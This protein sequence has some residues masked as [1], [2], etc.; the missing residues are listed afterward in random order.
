MPNS[1]SPSEFTCQKLD[2][3]G[4][5][6]RLQNAMNEYYEKLSNASKSLEKDS[7]LSAKYL[8]TMT[9]ND[10]LGSEDG[11]PFAQTFIVGNYCAALLG[12]QWVRC[13]IIDIA[14]NSAQIECVDDGRSLRM[15]LNKLENLIDQFKMLPRVAF[16]CKLALD[17][18]KLL[19]FNLDAIN[20]F[21]EMITQ[22]NKEFMVE[23]LNEYEEDFHKIFEVNLYH[24]DINVIDLLK[25]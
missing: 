11:D 25:S 22:I 23:I 3:L 21:K 7:K 4:R 14:S 24:N 2:L 1:F 17:S 20:K 10:S 5:Y 8:E 19:T 18:T 12:K 16:K 15:P 9:Y 13:V 6:D